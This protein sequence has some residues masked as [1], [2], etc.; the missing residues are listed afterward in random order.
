MSQPHLVLL[1]SKYVVVDATAFSVCMYDTDLM[2]DTHARVKEELV[3][4]SMPIFIFRSL[5]FTCLF[6][7]CMVTRQWHDVIKRVLAI[8]KLCS[9]LPW[10]FGSGCH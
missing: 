9:T 10:I 3:L 2:Y 6:I 7:I 5:V 8:F 1:V 4:N